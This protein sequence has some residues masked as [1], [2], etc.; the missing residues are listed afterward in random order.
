M[1]QSS[2][3]HGL[4]F[5][6]VPSALVTIGSEDD[7]RRVFPVGWLGVVCDSPPLLAVCLHAGAAKQELLRMGDLFS[8]DLPDEETIRPPDSQR[9]L[10]R[11]EGL[12][13]SGPSLPS[14]AG[15]VFWSEPLVTVSPVRMECRCCSLAVRYGQYW[16]R[17]EIFAVYLD[18]HR[19]EITA[20]VDLCRLLPLQG[21]RFQRRDERL[22]RREGC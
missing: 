18:G 19:Q 14:L 5:L 21:R 11:L 16:L 6:P 4:S 17:G 13:E 22:R 10:D 20:A 7:G 2:L 3:P 15:Q 9:W 1:P 12:A 8:V